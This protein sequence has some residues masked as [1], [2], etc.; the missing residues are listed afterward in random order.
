LTSLDQE[1]ELMSDKPACQGNR[2]KR[3]WQTPRVIVYGDARQLT[4]QA[5]LK[6]PGLSDDFQVPGVSDA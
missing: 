6:Q 2:E 5:K 1:E 3:A 4:Q